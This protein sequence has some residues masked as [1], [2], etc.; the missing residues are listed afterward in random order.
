MILF[1]SFINLSVCCL[2]RALVFDGHLNPG[3][4]SNNPSMAIILHGIF[5]W[6]ILG[7]V[8][9]FILDRR[10][11]PFTQFAITL[12]AALLLSGYGSSYGMMMMLPVFL[13]FF[14]R[15][16]TSKERRILWLLFFFVAS[17]FPVYL[18]QK[19]P[20]FLQ[21]PRFYAFILILLFLILTLRP[22]LG[23]KPVIVVAG[24]FTFKAFVELRD[25]STRY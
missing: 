1:R 17:N 4:F 12:F 20:L 21:F 23:W 15:P 3:A 25:I 22:K 10:L 14:S 8:L 24:L 9:L 19:W 5:Q 7:C 16:A 2:N 11:K 13:A 18:L 6:L